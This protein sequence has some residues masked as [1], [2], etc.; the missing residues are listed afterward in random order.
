MRL[1]RLFPIVLILFFSSCYTTRKSISVKSQ[2]ISETMIIQHPMITDLDVSASKVRGTATAANVELALVKDLAVENALK[3]SQADVMVEPRF[4][5]SETGKTI[6]VEVEGWP[7][8]YTNFRNV[9]PADSTV[10]NLYSS[11]TVRVYENEADL[12]EKKKAGKAILVS[13]GV[14][15]STVILILL[16]SGY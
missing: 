2:D 13:L 7:A 9:S 11:R 15:V 3:P 10:L 14:A 4:T 6:T 12:P 1:H 8:H 5:V 16:A